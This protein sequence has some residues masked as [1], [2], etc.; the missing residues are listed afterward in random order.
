MV[1]KAND[2][3]YDFPKPDHR[4][5]PRLLHRRRPRARGVLRP[6]HRSDNSTF[7]DSGRQARPRLR[8]PGHQAA[9]RPGRAVL[10]QGDLLSRRAS[11]TP[12]RRKTMGLVNRVVPA[13][14]ARDLC[15]GLR[16]D[17]RRQRAAHRQGGQ[18]HRQRDGARTS[19]SATSTRCA[20][21]G[22]HCFDSKDYI[23]GRRA[24]MEKRK[25]AFTGRLRGLFGMDCR[26]TCGIVGRHGRLRCWYPDG[27][28]SVHE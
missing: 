16:R 15:E 6:A 1:A 27:A 21:V 22:E 4:D 5:D 20:D 18:V 26:R 19:P 7:R 14:A 13:D 8:L 10:H 3:L 23:E 2:A 24:F 12:T 25:P 11:S 17:D 28:K 9:V